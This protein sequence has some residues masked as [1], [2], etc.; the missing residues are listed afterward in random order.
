MDPQILIDYLCKFSKGM[1]AQFKEKG[2]VLSE[3]QAINHVFK[4]GC[5][6]DSQIIGDFLKLLDS[7]KKFLQ[8]KKVRYRKWLFRAIS[9]FCNTSQ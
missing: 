1:L 4:V 8:F 2:Y 6:L 3:Q 5:G 7:S 9:Q